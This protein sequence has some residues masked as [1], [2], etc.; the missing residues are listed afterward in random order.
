MKKL[1]LPLVVFIT[2]SSCGVEFDPKDAGIETCKCFEDFANDGKNVSKLLECKEKIKFYNSVFIK[3]DK[4]SKDK[5]STMYK[6]YS[7]TWSQC[8]A[9][10][11]IKSIF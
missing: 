9:V 1:L 3:A 11:L 4:F 6:A 7:D 8:V 2:T 10:D 5:D